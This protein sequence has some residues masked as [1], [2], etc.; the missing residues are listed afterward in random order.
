MC[1]QEKVEARLRES[2]VLGPS[3]HLGPVHAT[4]RLFYLADMY[5]SRFLSDGMEPAHVNFGLI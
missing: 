3:R 2:H 1:L 4:W 5:F